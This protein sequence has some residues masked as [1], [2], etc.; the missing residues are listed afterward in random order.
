MKKVVIYSRFSSD[1]QDERSIQDQE[2]TCVEYAEKNGWTVIHKFADCGISGA[3]ML[4]RPEMQKMLQGASSGL[5]DIVLSEALDRLSRDMEDTASIYKKLNFA[6]VTL[7][8]LSEGVVSQMHVGFKGTMNSM[9]IEELR[10]KTHRGLQGRAL[11]GKSAGGK[12]YGY[13]TVRSLDASG[14]PITGE[15]TVNEFEASI[16]RRIFS[17]YVRGKSPKKIAFD[18][19]EE[20]VS[21]PTGG[22]WGASTIYGNRHRGTG[23]LNNELYIGRQVWNRQRYLKDPTTGKRVSR[24][25]PESEW[26]V[27]EVPELR[28][29]DQ[30]QW[31]KVKEYQGVLEKKI[32]PNQKR[33]PA[34]LLSFLLKCGECSGGM[35]IVSKGRYGCSTARNKGT[36]GCRTTISQ[37]ELEGR[38]LDAIK[39]RLM[40]PELT[41]VFCQEYVSQLNRT[42]IERNASITLKQKELAKIDRE[43][44]K[45]YQAMLDG[46]DMSF[47]K[48]K[49]TALQAR[50]TE[51][52]GFLDQ[53]EEAPVYVHPNMA[54]RYASAVQGLMENL[55]DPEHRQEAA[56]T[57]RA[58]V[59]EI[60][61]TPNED[62]SA[63]IV[64]MKGDLAAI[65]SVADARS[66]KAMPKAADQMETSERK[67][68]EQVETLVLT[69]V[70]DCEPCLQSTK[71]KMVAGVGFEPTTF[72]L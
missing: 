38:V 18:L 36:C 63:L 14:E 37:A 61:L 2:R 35:S 4:N 54:Q 68:L 39:S 45:A 10:R 29:I 25:N 51:V 7:H 56:K 65:L 3:S 55:N 27:S 34:H 15:R 33:R 30:E 72:R 70:S 64:D 32:A 28:I 43:M 24:P 52:E 50:K 46:L 47:V 62:A 11:K 49:M 31:D 40:D 57:I 53:T 59:S 69:S 67:E 71:G 17:E 22:A 19:N 1:M 16:V 8:T 20:G 44:E 41:K 48:E 66:K 21:A 42:R 12:S 9:F 60:V 6:D 58:L 13:D 5:F 23:V 26:V